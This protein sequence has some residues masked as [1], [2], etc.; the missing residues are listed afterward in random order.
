LAAKDFVEAFAS[1][2]G[3]DERSCDVTRDRRQ[4]DESDLVAMRVLVLQ[5]MLG[6]VLCHQHLLVVIQSDHIPELLG[7][8]LKHLGGISNASIR[9]NNR[10]LL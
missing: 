9:D 4:M 3:D 1:A 6:C 8:G 2:I 5:E 7:I 10:V